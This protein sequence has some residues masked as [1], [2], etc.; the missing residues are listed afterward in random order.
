MVSEPDRKDEENSFRRLVGVDGFSYRKTGVKWDTGA[1]DDERPGVN[2]NRDCLF[3]VAF[4]VC[5]GIL[6]E[7]RLKMRGLIK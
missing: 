3:F 7:L 6:S 1:G 5:G 4:R 2:D